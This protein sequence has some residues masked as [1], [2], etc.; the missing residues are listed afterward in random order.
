MTVQDDMRL[1]KHHAD[2]VKRILG[3]FFGL[4]ASSFIQDQWADQKEA[5]DFFVLAAPTIRCA[6]RLRTAKWLIAHPFDITIRWSRPNGTL[7]EIDK[8]RKGTVKYFL[9]GFVSEDEKKIDAYSILEIPF[10]FDLQPYAIKVNDPPDSQFGIFHQD[11]FKVLKIWNRAKAYHLP[12]SA[13]IL[14]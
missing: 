13:E 11:Q 10:P 14:E 3:R 4:D 8:I 2:M 7:T 6:L 5:T 9:Y 12:S 1:E